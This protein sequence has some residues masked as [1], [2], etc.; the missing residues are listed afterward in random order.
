MDAAGLLHP[1]P[2]GVDR[3]HR[4]VLDNADVGGFHLGLPKGKPQVVVI[5]HEQVATRAAHGRD[6]LGLKERVDAGPLDPL[7]DF[8][9][10]ERD[11]AHAN[12]CLGRAE[13]ED[14][15]AD[16]GIGR[17]NGSIIGRVVQAGDGER[18]D[19]AGR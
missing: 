18:H 8:A 4:Q 7:L 11:R 10:L 5:D 6:R 17:G 13:V 2:E 1:A 3:Q 12:G 14:R 15:D 19:P 16:G 9:A